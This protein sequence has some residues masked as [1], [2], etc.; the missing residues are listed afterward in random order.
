MSMEQRQEMV[1]SPPPQMR[2]EAVTVPILRELYCHS[3]TER[4]GDVQLD[5]IFAGKQ[6]VSFRRRSPVHNPSRWTWCV[7]HVDMWGDE[8]RSLATGQAEAVKLAEAMVEFSGG[9]ALITLREKV[10]GD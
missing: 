10:F 1:G 5:D 7:I 6:R 3:I 4:G 9:A 8:T 2:Q